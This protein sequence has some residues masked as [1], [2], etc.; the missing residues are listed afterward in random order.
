[1]SE[2]RGSP[3][4]VKCVRCGH[5]LEF[6]DFASSNPADTREEVVERILPL[7]GWKRTFAGWQ[8]PGTHKGIV[9]WTA[10]HSMRERLTQRQKSAMVPK[11]MIGIAPEADRAAP[12]IT[13]AMIDAGW[14]VLR[15][16]YPGAEEA[17]RPDHTKA[18]VE[19]FVIRVFRAR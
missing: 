6:G 17:S 12:E 7:I 10:L 1:M 3:L 14:A 19:E 9:I 13:P 4:A 15:E 8:C 2:A 5:A 11:P 18:F 16:F